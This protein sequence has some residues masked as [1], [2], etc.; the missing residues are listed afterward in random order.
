MQGRLIGLH[1]I[2]TSARKPGILFFVQL[3]PQA[4]IFKRHHLWVDIRPLTHHVAERHQAQ[5]SHTANVWRWSIFGRH[6][7]S[8]SYLWEHRGNRYIQILWSCD[9]F[10][11]HGLLHASESMVMTSHTGLGADNDSWDRKLKPWRP[12]HYKPGYSMHSK[13]AWL[14]QVSEK[15]GICR[16]CQ[17]SNFHVGWNMT[18]KRFCN[19]LACRNKR[20]HYLASCDEANSKG[21]QPNPVSRIC[22]WEQRF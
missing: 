20:C 8:S 11:R 5:A 17:D 4:I 22:I 15:S 2:Q 10:W 6:G 12:S 13:T 16:W 7:I 19:L 3:L 9:T 14:R 1:H 21:L 18:S